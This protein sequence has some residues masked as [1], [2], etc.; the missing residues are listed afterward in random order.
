[1]ASPTGPREKE[2]ADVRLETRS[3]EIPTSDG[4][5]QFRRVGRTNDCDGGATL[6]SGPHTNSQAARAPDIDRQPVGRSIRG[7]RP[8]GPILLRSVAYL[9]VRRCP[10]SLALRGRG[11]R[12]SP[13]MI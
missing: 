6:S 2:R 7:L 3:R 12:R 10:P 1:M 4:P 13:A 9:G 11:P 8:S 5:T